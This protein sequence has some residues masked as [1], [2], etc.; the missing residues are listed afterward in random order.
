MQISFSHD[1]LAITIEDDA[2]TFYHIQNIIEKNFSKRIGRKNKTIVF[3]QENENVQRRYFLK[4]I[5][6]IYKRK[7]EIPDKNIAKQIK[8]SID[9]SIKITHLKSNQLQQQLKIIMKIED[10][11]AINFNLGSKNSILVSY[12]RNY[13]K[14]HLVKYKLKTDTVVIYPVS[15]IT[16]KLLEK[17]LTRKEI[18]GCYVDFVYDIDE[19][20]TY[21]NILT[22]KMERK[23]KYNALFSLLEEYYE[24]LECKAEDSFDTIRK[25]YLKLVKQYHP[26]TISY[27]DP[28]LASHYSNKFQT[29]QNA[30]EMIKIHYEHEKTA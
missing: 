30:Y 15:E 8:T 1:M 22:K 20:L 14:D 21:Q 24:V 9:K 2:K 29:I 19:F 4:L 11:Y 5:S 23:R 17:L 12:L 28:S 13:F 16:S 10:N 18:I 26:D 27:T 6:K 3:K 25:N 7:N